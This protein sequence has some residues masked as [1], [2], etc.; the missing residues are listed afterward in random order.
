MSDAAP[1]PLPYASPVTD[2]R[3]RHHLRTALRCGG[4]PLIT[5]TSV[6]VAFWITRHPGL[7]LIG[8][9]TI[10]CGLIIF[11]FGVAQLIRYTRERKQ[12]FGR[13]DRSTKLRI[14]F[15]GLLLLLNFPVAVL[16]LLM[17]HRLMFHEPW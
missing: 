8:L 3:G 13:L 5:G 11:A 7:A 9:A 16:C 15:A 2:T 12:V 17:G 4:I 14:A 1:T 6:L 10:G